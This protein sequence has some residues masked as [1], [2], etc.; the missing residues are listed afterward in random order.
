M[1]IKLFRRLLFICLPILL[2]IW[3]SVYPSINS[4]DKKF[5]QAFAFDWKLPVDADSVHR[6]FENEI[7]FISKVQD[8]VV[9]TIQHEEIDHKFYGSVNYYYHYRKGYCYDRAVLMEKIFSYYGFNF[10]H[11]YIYF[12]TDGSEAGVSDFFKRKLPSHGI[13]EVK[14]KKGWM[15][16]DS[17]ANWIGL[18]NDNQ[19][20]TLSEVRTKLQQRKLSLAKDATMGPRFWADCG[21]H[22]KFIYGLYSRHGDFFNHSTVHLFGI[23]HFLPDYNLKM[24]FYN[25]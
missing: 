24:L 19:V 12:G 7:A 14:T 15:V 13:L 8:S 11:V 6:N 16:M 9:Y 2:L 5:I 21:T 22:F 10:R 17:N 20:M 18:D 4:E 1:S 25:F 3:C 23:S